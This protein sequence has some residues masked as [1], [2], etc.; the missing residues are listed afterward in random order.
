MDFNIL[1]IQYIIF[2]N[3][4]TFETSVFFRVRAC[5]KNAPFCGLSS[6]SSSKAT[7]YY[8]DKSYHN[9]LANSKQANVFETRTAVYCPEHKS[10]HLA[11]IS[12]HSLKKR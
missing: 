6:S 2:Q 7:N 3:L 5:I 10:L 8:Q 4:E 9:S 1:Q 12:Y 11:I